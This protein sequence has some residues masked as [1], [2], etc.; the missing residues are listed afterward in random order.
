MAR[1]TSIKEA[2]ELWEEKYQKSAKEA[3]EVGLQFQYPPIEKM[4]NTL[5][6]LIECRYI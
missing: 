4:D 6:T 5:A 3:T 2:L 1:A